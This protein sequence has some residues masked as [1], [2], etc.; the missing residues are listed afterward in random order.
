MDGK[1]LR[2]RGRESDGAGQRRYIRSP[3]PNSCG[4][5]SPGSQCARHGKRESLVRL[6]PVVTRKCKAVKRK[7]S[8]TLSFD[9][10]IAIGPKGKATGRP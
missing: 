2:T 6:R 5:V 10:P 1:S 7:S 3:V 4:G 8:V 9:I